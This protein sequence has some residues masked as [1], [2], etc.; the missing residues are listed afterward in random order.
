MPRRYVEFSHGRALVV[1]E[2]DRDYDDGVWM[3]SSLQCRLLT[4][5]APVF[6]AGAE[7]GGT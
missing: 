5:T 4:E 1:P 6:L 3:G 7:A 2:E